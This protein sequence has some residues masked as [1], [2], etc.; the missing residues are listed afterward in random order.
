MLLPE[1]AEVQAQASHDG[2]HEPE[3]LLEVAQASDDRA[4]A[5]RWLR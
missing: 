1:A 5:Q 2:D 4:A 3:A